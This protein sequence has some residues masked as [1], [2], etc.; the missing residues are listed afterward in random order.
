MAVDVATLLAPPVGAGELERMWF[1]FLKTQS[2]IEDRLD[3]FRSAAEA[4]VDDVA[5]ASQDTAVAAY[6]NWKAFELLAAEY[7]RR[8]GSIT[9]PNQG[10][11]AT[12]TVTPKEF[13]LKANYWRLQWERYVPDVTAT[14]GTGNAASVTSHFRF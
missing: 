11:K 10:T 14:P 7:G 4:L 6:V 12:G 9:L 2:E 5:V 13:R 1:D 8:V 3:G